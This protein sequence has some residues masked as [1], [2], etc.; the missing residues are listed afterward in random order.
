MKIHRQTL[1]LLITQLYTRLEHILGFSRGLCTALYLTFP[2]YNIGTV[3]L[4]AVKKTFIESDMPL[5]IGRVNIALL[6]SIV[7]DGLQVGCRRHTRQ[8][9]GSI[10]PLMRLLL[11][12]HLR[13]AFLSISPPGGF[14]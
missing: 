6:H 3:A 13:Q 14:A 7:E 1:L 5:F 10:P 2:K 9:G 12:T 8:P 4:Q 11:T